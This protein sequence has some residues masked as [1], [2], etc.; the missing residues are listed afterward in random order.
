M[1]VLLPLSIW[2]MRHLDARA[3]MVIGLAAFGVA[4]LLGTQLTHD[5][6][7]GDFI[8]MVLLQSV[9]QT[10]TLTP[11][12]VLAL[13]NA[14][15]ARATAFAAYIQ[16]MRLGGAEIGISLMATWLRVRE[17]VHSNFL[18]QHIVSGS[19]DVNHMLAKLSQHFAGSGSGVAP[20]RALDLL[21]TLVQREANTLAYID[22]FWLTVWFAIAALA[23]V[24]L[25]GPSPKGPLSPH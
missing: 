17:Q 5:W 3:V 9:G 6:S 13:S 21:S 22:G 14:D 15:P 8:P 10:F 24:A 19:A 12:V 25:I 20:A 2:L 1:L 18:G 4:S 11:I 7:L 16:V 23:L